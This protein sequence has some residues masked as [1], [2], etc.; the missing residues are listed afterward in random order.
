[1]EL[2]PKKVVVVAESVEAVGSEVDIR[3]VVV[4]TERRL[5]MDKES[6]M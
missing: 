5:H 6:T 1:M 2:V 4:R 3:K